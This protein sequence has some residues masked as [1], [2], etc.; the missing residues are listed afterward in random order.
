MG[1]QMEAAHCHVPPGPCKGTLGAA[2][3]YI[4]VS[5]THLQSVRCSWCGKYLP[6]RER[7]LSQ[8]QNPRP[9]LISH[10][11]SNPFWV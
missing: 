9:D 10:N 8:K 1:K 3:R 7:S 6:H 5:M 2:T 4:R 11:L